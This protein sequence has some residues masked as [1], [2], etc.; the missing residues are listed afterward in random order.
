MLRAFLVFLAASTALSGC[1]S[2]RLGQPRAAD[3]QAIYI[4]PAR[5]ESA[6]PQLEAPV[7]AAVRQALSRSEAFSLANESDADA[8]LEIRLIEAKREMAAVLSEDVGRARKLQLVVE[9]GV[10]LHNT[11]QPGAF[12][13]RDRRFVVSQDIFTDSG[14]ISA[15]YHAGPALADEI[16]TRVAELLADTW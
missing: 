9:V 2:Y 11:R 10:D 5:N 14:Q 8:K 15:E 16:A 6:L 4:A 1:A 13:I 3:Y 12:Y 7:N